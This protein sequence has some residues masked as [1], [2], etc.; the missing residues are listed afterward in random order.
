MKSSR[1]A[2][3][4]SAFV[5]AVSLSLSSF[6]AIV[7]SGPL[8]ITVPQN[9]DGIYYN[10]VTGANGATGAGT[11]GWDIN[12][13]Q[14][15]A[16]FGISFFWP[17]PNT[18]AGGVATGTVYNSLA[19]G[20]VINAASNFSIAAGG[21][22]NAN[23]VNYQ[24]AGQKTLG[25]RFTNE[26]G[27]GVHFGY[28]NFTTSGPLGFPA[29]ITRIVYDNVAGTAVTVAGAGPTATVTAG[30]APGNINL[31]RTLPTSTSTSTLSFTTAGAPATVNC[32]A[33]GTGYTVAP[34]SLA[35]AVG[36][37]GTVTVTHTGTTAGSFPGVV[38]CTPAAPAAGGPFVYNYTTTVN[39]AA[40]LV[41]A[42]ALNSFGALLLLAGIG[43]FGAFSVRRFS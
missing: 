2:V 1:L 33:T 15:D 32:A 5:G 9:L 43:L 28:I 25:I 6:A 30:T 24:T 21:G 40:A 13:Y 23:F 29:Q 22:G 27:G 18:N 10:V 7:D 20:A 35:L 17:T 14:P 19:V 12:V 31:T 38:T 39:A 3:Q 26:A 37:P 42:P 41:Q 34:A 8:T 4:I 36:T 11:A 16:A